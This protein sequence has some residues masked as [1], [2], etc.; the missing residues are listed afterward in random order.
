MTVDMKRN[1]KTLN[2]VLNKDKNKVLD[3]SN[4]QSA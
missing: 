4:I 2:E 1:L 3:E